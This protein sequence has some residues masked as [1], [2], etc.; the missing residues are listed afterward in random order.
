MRSILSFS[1]A[2]DGPTG[3]RFDERYETVCYLE[4]SCACAG[5]SHCVSKWRSVLRP[6]DSRVSP[7]CETCKKVSLDLAAFNWSS[8]VYPWRKDFAEL[9]DELS[10]VSAIGLS[11][12]EVVFDLENFIMEVNIAENCHF[13]AL[14]SEVN[15]EL[16]KACPQCFRGP[17]QVFL[18][19][20]DFPSSLVRRLHQPSIADLLGPLS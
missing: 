7:I 2:A 16:G 1:E 9:R 18:Q 3:F 6:Q 20:R 13:S 4:Y 14:L 19:C 12:L 15:R 17:L 10:D 8:D 11:V 5:Q